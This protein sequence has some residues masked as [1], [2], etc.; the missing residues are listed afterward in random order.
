M[1][2]PKYEEVPVKCIKVSFKEDKFYHI[3][4]QDETDVSSC[5]SITDD[6][7]LPVDFNEWDNILMF[8]KFQTN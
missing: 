3:F 8:L 5:M 4:L 6:M 1:L 7:G 2:L